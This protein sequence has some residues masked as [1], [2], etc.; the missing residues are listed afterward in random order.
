MLTE[1]RLSDLSDRL[2]FFGRDFQAHVASFPLDQYTC[3]GLIGAIISTSVVV[4]WTLK[5]DLA[6]RHLPTHPDN[7]EKQR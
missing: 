3:F 2:H 5:T 1:T 6:A 4:V 7:A